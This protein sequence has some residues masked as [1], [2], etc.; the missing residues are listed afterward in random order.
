MAKIV[1][2]DSMVAAKSEL[3]F[4]SIP[5]TQVSVKDG[6]WSQHSLEKAA[7]DTGPFR[8][9]LPSDS[10]FYDL[11][12]NYLQLTLQIVNADGSNLA[13]GADIASINLIGKTF[14]ERVIVKIQGKEVF[15]SGSLYAY[16]AYLETLLNYGTEAKSSEL[17]LA[18]FFKENDFQN[19]AASGGYTSRRARFAQS[20][21]VDLFAP[22]HSQLFNTG[23]YMLRDTK[24]ELE[25]HRNKDHFV[26]IAPN[27]DTDYKCKVI[28]VNWHVWKVDLQESANLA[29]DQRLLKD[30]A[31]YPIRRVSV[32]NT[33]LNTRG[34]I[35]S[36]NNLLNGDIPRRLIL[37]LVPSKNFAGSL[38]TNPFNFHHYNVNTVELRVGG[39]EIKPLKM[40]FS[41]DNYGMAYM[42]LLNGIGIGNADKGISISYAEYKKGNTLFV[43][44]LTADGVDS[45]A[46]G[47]IK[48][49]T[50]NL[51]MSFDN[52][53]DAGGGIEL[54]A[55]AE[56]DGVTEIDMNRVVFNDY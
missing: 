11:S 10:Y 32:I 25:L 8:L 51:R 9:E 16:Q 5:P 53:L 41:N 55:Y 22:I 39:K 26:L 7:T 27:A 15:N 1:H 48:S 6:F 43:F 23:R 44:D 42:Y 47:L 20:K 45:D 34:R 46:M 40:D 35:V 31:K 24:I 49:G 19:V 52:N 37:G 28:D 13:A 33:E 29:I 54:I 2:H 14:F 21:Q 12:K 30:T 17:Q 36:V 4:F 18:L 38:D 50:V 56:F 3:D